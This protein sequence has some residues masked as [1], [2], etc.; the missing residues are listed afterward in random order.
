MKEQNK[1]PDGAAGIFAV[2][3]GAI[4]VVLAIFVATDSGQKLMGIGFGL[5][6]LGWGSRQIVVFKKR[7]KNLDDTDKKDG[8]KD[9]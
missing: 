7:K 6:L 9:C 2:A 5:T 4:C 1:Q 3:F 8:T